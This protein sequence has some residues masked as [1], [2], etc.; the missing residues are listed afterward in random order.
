[1][2]TPVLT[3]IPT[4]SSDVIAA[5]KSTV[6]QTEA[7][8]DKIVISDPSTS[9]EQVASKGDLQLYYDSKSGNVTVKNTKT[10]DIWSTNPP[11][12]IDDKASSERMIS[13]LF[14]E[15]TT[16]SGV[17]KTVSSYAG[18][19]FSMK[20]T[21]TGICVTYTF[22][23]QK[24]TIPITYSL[25]N[26]GLS[27]AIIIKDIKTSETS[28]VLNNIY[29]LE[30]FGAGSRQDNGFMLVPDG[31]GALI[32]FNNGKSTLPAYN[33]DVFGSD[34]SLRSDSYVVSSRTEKITM[35]VFGIIRNGSGCLAEITEGAEMA[36]ISAAV[37]GEKEEYNHV[38]STFVY[39]VAQKL[40][41]MD[42]SL[43]STTD[44][45]YT[46]LEKVQTNAFSL[47]YRLLDTR[48]AGVDELAACYRQVLQQQGV[49]KSVTAKRS[50]V[51][52]FYGGVTRRRSFLGILY[53]AKEK[54]TSFSQAQTILEDLKNGGIDSI[55]GLYQNY[56]NDFFNRDLQINLSAASAIGG[57]NGLKKLLGFVK[58][59][60]MS[61]GMSADF[62][63]M[64]TGGNGFSTFFDVVSSLNIS[65]VQVYR[66]NL[67]SNVK[68]NSRKPYYLIA[69]EKYAKAVSKLLDNAKKRQ[70]DSLYFDEDALALYADYSKDNMMRSEAKNIWVEQIA[71]I[72]KSQELTMANPNAYM[73]PYVDYITDMPMQS[74]RNLIFDQDV[75]FAQMAISGLL[76]YSG[77]SIN[78]NNN[79]PESFL[80]L[81]SYGADI[82]YCLIQSDS[83]VLLTTD[84]T[85][86][87][88]VTYNGLQKE[89]KDR[90]KIVADVAK[91]M[92]GAYITDYSSVGPVNITTYSN[93]KKLYVNTGKTSA[94]ADDS[95]IDALSYKIN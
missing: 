71:L 70:F 23:S 21:S 60:K 53:Q 12:A 48:N 62:I 65:P 89:I 37:C 79:S 14:L 58:E 19:T 5:E 16:S 74:S 40:P 6:A 81:L 54:L 20:K 15:F 35:P 67:S 9:S 11:G 90:A 31:C 36:S 39:Q 47:R 87:Y 66:Y 83:D 42:Q 56:S 55:R 13:Q 82:K 30:Y 46:A 57:N 49:G 18:S 75:P 8:V 73:L 22:A 38:F 86:L 84:L 52:E 44:V 4:N 80:H 29:F 28:S 92:D 51:T 43:A 78:I 61:M 59:Q 10:G 32:K 3:N 85:F 64:P 34:L 2:M 76:P 91:V 26:D 94:Q 25:E 7:I 69:P 24:I 88:A 77:V 45:L 17:Q 68:D 27:A 33:K 95:I 41:L 72:A 93:G 1:M 63:S 50:L